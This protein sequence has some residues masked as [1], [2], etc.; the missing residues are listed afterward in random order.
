MLKKNHLE[1]RFKFLKINASYCTRCLILQNE[2]DVDEILI[3]KKIQVSLALKNTYILSNYA[4]YDH[5]IST[6]KYEINLNTILTLLVSNV[7]S[8][9][10][11]DTKVVQIL[12]STSHKLNANDV[13]FNILLQDI[14]YLLSCVHIKCFIFTLNFGRTTFFCLFYLVNTQKEK[15][16]MKEGERDRM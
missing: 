15:N 1:N 13:F 12:D 5:S 11:Y 9:Y 7:F 16:L 2:L 8:S 14:F 6:L 4:Y 3:V 10:S